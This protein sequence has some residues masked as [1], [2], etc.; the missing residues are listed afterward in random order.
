MQIFTKIDIAVIKIYK[1]FYAC[2]VI[3]LQ[4]LFDK[5]DVE[6]IFLKSSV[7]QYSLSLFAYQ[8]HLDIRNI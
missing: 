7:K 5:G 4:H 6:Y 8:I 2:R 1:H 3:K